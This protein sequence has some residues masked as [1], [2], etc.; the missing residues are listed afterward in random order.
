MRIGVLLAQKVP[1]TLDLLTQPVE[2]VGQGCKVW[3]G[4]GPL[5]LAGGFVG[6]QLPFPVP[7]RRCALIVLLASGSF[8]APAGLPDLLVKVVCLRPGT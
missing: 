2:F 8:F 5:L 6:E 7:Q 4:A 1:K 3:V